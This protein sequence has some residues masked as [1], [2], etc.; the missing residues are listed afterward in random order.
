MSNMNHLK[1]TIRK[2]IFAQRKII[3][4]NYASKANEQISKNL[5]RVLIQYDNCAAIGLYLSMQGEPNIFEIALKIEKTIALPKII[6]NSLIFV[7]YQ[8][9]DPLE[10]SSFSKLQQPKFTQE[11]MPEIIIVPGLCFSLKGDRIGFGF[12]HYD[13]Y[14]GEIKRFYR[15]IVVGV[16]FHANLKLTL[17]NDLNDQKMNFIIT[18]QLIL[19]I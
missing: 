4:Q 16:C 13:R 8:A 9:G 1:Q 2:E 19:K 6:D 7:K 18:D 10:Q 3:E 14:L 17:P 5:S 11:I 12:G 15:P